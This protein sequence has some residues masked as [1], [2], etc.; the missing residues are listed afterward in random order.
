MIVRKTEK[1]TRLYVAVFVI[2]RRA[3][4]AER[5]ENDFAN[6]GDPEPVPLLGIGDKIPFVQGVQEFGN[7]DRVELLR[8]GTEA[9]W[10]HVRHI[11]RR[12]FMFFSFDKGLR[13]ARCDE[14]V[15]VTDRLAVDGFWQK[16]IQDRRPASTGNGREIVDPVQ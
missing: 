11:F 13:R 16:Y 14:K 12:M 10:I 7:S 15:I 5:F 8:C 9:K 4:E 3:V 2:V 1:T 6:G